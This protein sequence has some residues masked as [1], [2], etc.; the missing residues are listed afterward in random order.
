MLRFFKI[1]CFFSCCNNKWI[2]RSNIFHWIN[3]KP[4]IDEEELKTAFVYLFSN[5]SKSCIGQY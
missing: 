2:G 4:A 5:P 1:R 3:A